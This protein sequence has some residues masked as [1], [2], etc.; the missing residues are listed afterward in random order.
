ARKKRDLTCSWRGCL[1]W[2]LPIIVLV[3]TASLRTPYLVVIWPT[4]LVF[5]GGACFYN[6]RRCGRLHCFITGP[7][8]FLLALVS[9]L[10]ALGVLPLGPKGWMWLSNTLVLGSLVLT[11]CPEWIF[12]RYR[13]RS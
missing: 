9:L 13:S 3:V 7:F 4:L 11:Y 2:I 1:I 10:Y 8:F 12:G 5:M 6:G